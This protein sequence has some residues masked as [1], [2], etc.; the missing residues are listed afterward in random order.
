MNIYGHFPR[1]SHDLPSTRRE[2][3]TPVVSYFGIRIWFGFRASDFVV[4]AGGPRGAHLWEFLE[5]NAVFAESHPLLQPLCWR[6][7]AEKELALFF[8]SALAMVPPGL[9]RTVEKTV[10]NRHRLPAAPGREATGRFTGR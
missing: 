1:N 8:A 7:R 4:R 10:K 2:Q 9:I 6:G 3:S 5:G